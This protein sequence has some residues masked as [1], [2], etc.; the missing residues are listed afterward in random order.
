MIL[1][2][3]FASS[4]KLLLSHIVSVSCPPPAGAVVAADAGAAAL[5]AVLAGAWAVGAPPHASSSVAAP[6]LPAAARTEVRNFR[7]ETGLLI[8]TLL[9]ESARDLVVRCVCRSLFQTCS[10]DA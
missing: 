3:P 4:A 8:D 9:Y 2:S 5:P 1:S 7:R 6:T 10:H